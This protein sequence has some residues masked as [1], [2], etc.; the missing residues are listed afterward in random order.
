MANSSKPIPVHI[1]L[2]VIDR[3]P[4]CPLCQEL[5]D[6]TMTMDESTLRATF[7]LTERSLRHVKKPHYLNREEIE[8]IGAGK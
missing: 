6:A 2:K 3:A 8:Q 7:V 5:L 4:R 1:P